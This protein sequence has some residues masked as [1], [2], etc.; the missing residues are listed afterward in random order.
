[1]ELALHQFRVNFFKV[2]AH[3]LRLQLLQLLC[4]EGSKSVGELRTSVNRAG[5]IV[6]QQ[7]SILRSNH[8]VSGEKEGNR[9]VYS[10]ENPMIQELLELTKEIFHYQLMHVVSIL[11]S[12][13]DVS[14]E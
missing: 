14:P 1:M 11:E 8:L 4:D 12:R 3:P 5:S 9:V 10:I 6:S 13:S 7:L 2:M